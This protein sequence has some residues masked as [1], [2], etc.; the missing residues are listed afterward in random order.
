M[1]DATQ[2]QV[3]RL[4]EEVLSTLPANCA[5]LELRTPPK[6]K[7]IEDVA[8]VPT[9]E[10]SAEF[11]VTLIGGELYAVFFGRGTLSTTYECPWE[12][13]LR[14]RDGLAEHLAVIEKMCLAVI[15]GRCTHRYQ[16]LGIEGAIHVSERQAYRVR[17]VG[18]L[19]IFSPRRLVSAVQYAPYFPAAENH[20]RTFSRL[21]L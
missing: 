1:T 6:E 16:R 12:I 21:S 11:G 17:D 18:L 7:D 19:R 8:L 4:F 14:R 3:V 13:G 10:K 5:S 2:R 9:N 15:A 20:A